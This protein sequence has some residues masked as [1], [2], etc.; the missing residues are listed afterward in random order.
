[1]AAKLARFESS[2][3][4]ERVSRTNV[5]W[6]PISTVVP[7]LSSS[8]MCRPASAPTL[9]ENM[10]A[11]KQTTAANRLAPWP[12]A[13]RRSTRWAGGG[14]RDEG[15]ERTQ[16]RGR[17]RRHGR[18]THPQVEDGVAQARRPDKQEEG[19][20]VEEEEAEELVV[21]QPNT[22]GNP[23]GVGGRPALKKMG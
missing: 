13:G 7:L 21:V 8:E 14:R 10:S 5:G 23:T 17:E 2:L 3:K 15:Q 18:G 19:Q 20:H 16:K 4:P 11:R 6:R 1:M 9:R 22:I 12:W